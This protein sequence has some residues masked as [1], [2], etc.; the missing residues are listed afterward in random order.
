M[1]DFTKEAVHEVVA[2]KVSQM[3]TC[4]HQGY[5]LQE[6][7]LDDEQLEAINRGCGLGPFVQPIG[8]TVVAY[9]STGVLCD[10]REAYLQVKFA[11]G[12]DGQLHAATP[13]MSEKMRCCA[14]YKWKRYAN[15]AVKL[16]PKDERALL[17][18]IIL[19]LLAE[20]DK[21]AP[22][23]DAVEEMADEIADERLEQML[24]EEMAQAPG[25]EYSTVV[26]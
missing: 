5:L 23:F 4:E 6:L 1:L 10:V 20:R 14:L 15:D 11:V 19:D 2:A 17:G 8:A 24:D 22:I 26:N 7:Q 16:G 3:E 9:N 13:K 18:G 12:T 25:P 21:F